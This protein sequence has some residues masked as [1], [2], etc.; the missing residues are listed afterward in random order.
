MYNI[1]FKKPLKKEALLRLYESYLTVFNSTF[2]LRLWHNQRDVYSRTVVLYNN[3][4][5][6]IGVREN[7]VPGLVQ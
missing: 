3:E 7:C 2:V 5:H 4:K 6:V 1:N